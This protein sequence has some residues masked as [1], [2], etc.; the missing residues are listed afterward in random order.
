[1]KPAFDEMLD[2]SAG[3]REQY[4][5]FEQWLRAVLL[6]HASA[7]VQHFIKGWFHVALL[8]FDRVQVRSIIA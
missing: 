1:M 4:R 2:A 7:R 5:V 3:V 8:L 6:A